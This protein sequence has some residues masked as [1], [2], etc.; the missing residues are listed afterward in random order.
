MISALC[1]VLFIFNSLVEGTVGECTESC[2]S[3][4][5]YDD[6]KC[7]AI[8]AE[9]G[10][11][12][13]N[14]YDCSHIENRP[15]GH[16]HLQGKFYKPM[17][18]IDDDLIYGNCHVACRCAERAEYVC[19]ILDCPEWLGNIPYKPGCYLKYE[20]NKC[21]SMGQVCPPFD[22]VATCTVGDK[23]YKEGERFEAPD[24]RCTKCVCQ[25]GFDGKYEEPFC[26]KETCT[27][28]IIHSKAIRDNCA[29]AYRNLDDCCPWDWI[30]PEET[31]VIESSDESKSTSD[32]RCKFGDKSLKILDKFQRIT[33]KTE[34]GK[35]EI[36]CKCEVPPFLTCTVKYHI[37]PAPP[38]EI[39]RINDASLAT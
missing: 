31:D 23:V 37:K 39:I 29:P 2:Q 16:C 25:K 7:K 26:T 34:Y 11:C 12:C 30:C 3:A 13:P 6:L 22:D 28:E 27:A 1:C 17:E 24:R 18:S 36:N 4:L 38:L 14:Q 33:A 20:L 35:T 32:L 5:L 19:A 8:F 9:E 21:C 10:D 15:D